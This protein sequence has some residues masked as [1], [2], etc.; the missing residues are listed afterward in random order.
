[1]QMVEA[2][3]RNAMAS[4]NG[5]ASM[6]LQARGGG[7][8][9]SSQIEVVKSALESTKRAENAVEAAKDWFARG[10]GVFTNEVNT[11]KDA[12]QQLEHAVTQLTGEAQERSREVPR[13]PLSV[14]GG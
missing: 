9:A 14:G 11:I 6:A 3:V 13:S 10:V 12:R 7:A 4:A 1:M 5:L 8:V 2:A